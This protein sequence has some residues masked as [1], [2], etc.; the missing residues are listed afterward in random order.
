MIVPKKIN[1]PITK[2]LSVIIPVYREARLLSS[3]LL[4]L[5]AYLDSIPVKSELIVVDDGSGDTVSIQNAVESHAGILLTN[6]QNLGKGAAIQRGMLAANGAIRIFTDADLPYELEA[7]ERFYY[8]L[9]NTGNSIAIGDRNLPES[10][11]YNEVPL[12]R[13]LLSK[14][15]GHFVSLIL[16]GG[17]YDS[18]CGLKAFSAEAATDIFP[19]VRIKRYAFDVEILYIALKKGYKLSKLPVKLRNW[20]GS[21]MHIIRDGFTMIKDL[22]LIKL[23]YWTGAYNSRKNGK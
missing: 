14:L 16:P 23:N 8:H 21:N 20:E 12:I 6:P 7:I 13:K 18:Q 11:Y 2:H 4:D 19:L 15:F 17:N 10:R 9:A 1:M 3:N 5:S 22:L